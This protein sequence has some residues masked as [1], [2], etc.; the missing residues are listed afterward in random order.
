MNDPFDYA[1]HGNDG[2]TKGTKRNVAIKIDFV[3]DTI[4]LIRPSGSMRID[5]IDIAVDRIIPT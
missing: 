1:T 2:T 4:S 3:F 5:R